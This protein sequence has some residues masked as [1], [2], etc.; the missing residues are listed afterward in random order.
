MA[1]TDAA[2]RPVGRPRSAERE[3]DILDAALA[4]LVAEGYGAMTIEGVAARAGAGKATVYRRW[5]NKA[6]LVA[7][8]VRSHAS[9]QLP[10]ADTG[11][12]REDLRVALRAMHRSFHGIDGAVRTV[13]TA[14][15]I[16][17]PELGDAFERAFV[18]DRRTHLQRIIRRAVDRGELPA[19]TDVALLAD[20]GPALLLYEFV[21]RRGKV[22]ADFA[23]RV[24]AQFL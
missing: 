20:V 11:D 18:A 14:E 24:V 3:Q 23:D 9:A 22:R 12:V 15:R 8:A 5:R 16:R 13:F 7:D 2:T 4:A 19:T 6:E 17:H 10:D 21:L 1:R